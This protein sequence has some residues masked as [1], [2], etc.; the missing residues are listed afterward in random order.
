MYYA[1]G[2]HQS[3]ARTTYRCLFK[4]AKIPLPTNEDIEFPSFP[5]YSGYLIII[6]EAAAGIG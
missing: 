1:C 5:V 4:R 2:A 3:S 6:T